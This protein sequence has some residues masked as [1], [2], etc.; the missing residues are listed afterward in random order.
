MTDQLT[1]VDMVAENELICEK[2]LGWKRLIYTT[3]ILWERPPNGVTETPSFT[4]WADAGLILDEFE[5][6]APA[7]RVD[8]V[9]Y[10]SVAGEQMKKLG[11]LLSRGELRPLAIR[12]AALDY[13][14]SLP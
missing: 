8:S 9:N 11:V 13:V 5:S 14:R 10:R 7:E 3:C 12:A 6:R 2:L 4:T 1:E